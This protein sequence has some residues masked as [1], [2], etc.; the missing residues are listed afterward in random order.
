MR[1]AQHVGHGDLLEDQSERPDHTARRADRAREERLVG[2]LDR[3]DGGGSVRLEL[4]EQFGHGEVRAL[5]RRFENV[6]YEHVP[7]ERNRRA[8]QLVNV[9]IDAWLAEHP[10]EAPLDDPDQEQLF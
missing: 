8:D 5:A 4:G 2:G 9:A 10:D 6:A 7:R 1:V 3:P